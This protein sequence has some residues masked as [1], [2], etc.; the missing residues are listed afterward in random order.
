MRPNGVKC[1]E[2][3]T[4][5]T[6]AS[7]DDSTLLVYDQT[8]A[9]QFQICPGNSGYKKILKA[10]RDEPAYQGGKTYMKAAFDENNICTIFPSTAGVKAHYNW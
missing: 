2:Q 8:R 6:Q 10:V 9:C 5:K 4:V 7:R 3:F 1:N